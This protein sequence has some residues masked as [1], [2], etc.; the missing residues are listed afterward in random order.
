MAGQLAMA[1]I[2]VAV[3]SVGAT[4]ALASHNLHLIR[5]LIP[6]HMIRYLRHSF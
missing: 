2:L 3:I 1:L 5:S 4:A 6:D